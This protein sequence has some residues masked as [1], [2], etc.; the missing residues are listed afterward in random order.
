MITD[1]FLNQKIVNVCEHMVKMASRIVTELHMVPSLPCVHI[2]SLL[3]EKDICEHQNVSIKF[4]CL[5]SEDFFIFLQELPLSFPIF[6]V[7]LTIGYKCHFGKVHKFS[8]YPK[9]CNCFK[10]YM[11]NNFLG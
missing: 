6:C 8:R 5:L 2:Y 11:Y 10:Y 3:I 1:V 7:N 9:I 4:V